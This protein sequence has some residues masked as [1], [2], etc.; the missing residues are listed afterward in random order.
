MAGLDQI[1]FSNVIKNS[2]FRQKGKLEPAEGGFLQRALAY[3]RKFARESRDLEATGMG[4]WPYN[5]RSKA[6]RSADESEARIS[7]AYRVASADSWA[8]DIWMKLGQ[9]QAAEEAYRHAIA[10]YDQQI[11]EPAAMS[12]SLFMSD[13]AVSSSNKLRSRIWEEEKS[14]FRR[15]L[16]AS[17]NKLGSLLMNTGRLKEAEEAY[18]EALALRKQLAADFPIVT[19]D[20]RNLASSHYDLGTLLM[21]TGRLKEAETAYREVLVL[22][23]QSMADFPTVPEYRADLA[24]S[25]S[26]L[27]NLLKDTGRLQEAEETYREA[28]VLRKELAADFPAVPE[29]RQELASSHYD[30]GILR[31]SLGQ[32]GEAEAA[33]H[34]A[35]KIQTQLAK[36]LPKVP[37]YQNELAETLVNLASL[38]RNNKELGRARQLLEQALSHHRAALKANDRNPKYRASF[39]ENCQVLVQT[40]LELGDHTAAADAA[41][42]LV[43]AAVDPAGGVYAAACFLARCVP[44][45]EGDSKLTASQRQERAQA[46]ANRA[47]ATLRQAVQNGY[48]DA[49]HMKTDTDLDPLRS[50]EDFQKLVK[51]LED[52]VATGAK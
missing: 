34:D 43:Q 23:K 8:G 7:E 25:D 16:A 19:G 15:G 50:R 39:R 31:R 44:L 47:V 18:R 52:K 49:A 33:F 13:D 20:R 45:A 41:D 14:H 35:L 3:Y 51:E 17:H 6:Q 22:R 38:A 46:Y 40:L 21:N 12:H 37:D 36:D 32:R 11:A 42:Q 1:F 48:K 27:G 29:Y 30:L 4:S 2:L 10:C 24:S 26:N 9:H 5:I 28:L